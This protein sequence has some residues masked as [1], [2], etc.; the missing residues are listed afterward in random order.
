MNPFEWF[1]ALRRHVGIYTAI[2]VAVGGSIVLFTLAF[3]LAYH[4]SVLWAGAVLLVLVAFVLVGVFY[5]VVR[6]ASQTATNDTAS[7]LHTWLVEQRDAHPVG[8]DVRASWD[9][10]IDDYCTRTTAGEP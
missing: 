5:A 9:A 2:A 3:S 8:S 4:A 10:A 6:A 7:L 1:N